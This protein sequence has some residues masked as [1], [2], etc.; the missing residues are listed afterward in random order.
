MIIE[1]FPESIIQGLATAIPIIVTCLIV[2]YKFKNELCNQ[3][4]DLRIKVETH[5]AIAEKQ[6]KEFDKLKETLSNVI[7]KNRLES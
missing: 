5:I 1:T 3:I 4:S 2:L 6:E 7:L